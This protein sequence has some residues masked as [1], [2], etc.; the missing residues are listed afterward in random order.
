MN[1]RGKQYASQTGKL[2][3]KNTVNSKIKMQRGLYKPG[4]PDQ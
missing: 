1:E 2:P 4:Q 3:G